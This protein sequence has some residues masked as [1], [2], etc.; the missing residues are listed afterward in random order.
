MERNGKKIQA[1]KKLILIVHD[2]RLF[3][4]HHVYPLRKNNRIKLYSFQKSV[5]TSKS[6]SQLFL[7]SYSKI[8][9]LLSSNIVI[10]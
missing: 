4:K 1:M 9:K 3:K 5:T 2:H 10:S 8:L 6:I 7:K